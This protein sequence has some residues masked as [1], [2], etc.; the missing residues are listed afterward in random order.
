MFKVLSPESPFLQLLK[1]QGTKLLET[2]FSLGSVPLQFPLEESGDENEVGGV[3]GTSSTLSI[4]L[5]SISC[6]PASLSPWRALPRNRGWR[7]ET[8]EAKGPAHPCPPPR[9]GQEQEEE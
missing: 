7:L 9:P 2:I 3:P 5:H 6:F 8:A 4:L 1:N